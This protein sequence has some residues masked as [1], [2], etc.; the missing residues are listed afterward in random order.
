MQFE[1]TLVQVQAKDGSTETAK[2]EW[3]SG[4]QNLADS[5]AFVRITLDGRSEEESA[6]DFYSAFQRA[7]RSFETEGFRFLCYGASLNVWPS[8]M[9]RDM[10]MGR[11]GYKLH[12]GRDTTFDDL[13]P[14]FESGNDVIPSTVEEQCAY[15]NAWYE[16]APRRGRARSDRSWW[17][18]WR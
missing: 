8:G 3:G 9:V 12:K 17:Q 15:A 13:V 11:K 1:Q 14:I 18:F 16:D 6:F 5:R 10:G 2:I 7:R 4:P